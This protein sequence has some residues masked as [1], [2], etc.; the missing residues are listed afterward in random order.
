MTTRRIPDLRWT[1]ALTAVTA[2]PLAAQE[3]APAEAASPGSPVLASAYHLT[4]TSAWPQITGGLVGCRNGGHETVEGT[5]IRKADGVY[6]GVPERRT[7]LLFC[8]AHGGHGAACEL[9]LEGEGTV[10]MTGRV[11]A[12]ATSP[13]GQALRVSWTPA[14]THAVGVRGA[15]SAEFKRAVETMYL[16]A[17]HGAEFAVPAAGAG[18]RRERLEHYAW[19]VEVGEG[20]GRAQVPPRRLADPLPVIGS[21]LRTLRAGLS[22]RRPR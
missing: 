13:S 10:A 16:S 21:S 14:P 17:T 4:L 15:C 18:A 1:L 9:V 12:D 3:I 7:V 22:S 5:L 2:A 11:V 19:I 8:G 6:R 20:A